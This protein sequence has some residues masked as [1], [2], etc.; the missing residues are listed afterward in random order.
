MQTQVS[1]I[2]LLPLALIAGTLIGYTFGAIQAAASRRY[3]RLQLEGKFKSGFR[4]VTPGSFRRVAYLLVALA[5]V[6]FFFPMFFASGGLSQY[7]VSA[8]VVAGYGWMLYRQM[9]LRRA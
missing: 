7:C 2:F 3:E 6:Q 9:R 8:G 5:M 4:S 1:N